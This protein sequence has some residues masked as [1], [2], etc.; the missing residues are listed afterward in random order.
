M[1][2]DDLIYV[3]HMLDTA[4]KV[5]DKVKGV[6]RAQYD[7]DENLRISLAH[8]IQVIGEAARR[9]SPS[10]RDAHP[11]VPW[12]A[13]VGMRHKVVHDYM[14]VDDTVVW[15]TATQEMQQLIAAIQ[16]LAPPQEDPA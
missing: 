16:P 3:G 10:F 7:S 15:Q 8:L 13:I 11:E 9:V 1:P 14:N 12:Q 4:R 2:K 5:A 6:G